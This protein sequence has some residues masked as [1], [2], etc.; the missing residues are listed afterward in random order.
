MNN[1]NNFDNN[2]KASLSKHDLQILDSII[3]KEKDVFGF[4][5]TTTT[6][7]DKKNR[8]LQGEEEKKSFQLELEA[9]Q[10]AEMAFSNRETKD[11][12]DSILKSIATIERAIEIAPHLPSPYN[13]KAQILRQSHNI[14]P[15]NELFS[16][17]NIVENLH[18][19]LELAPCEEWPKVRVLLLM[20]L[21]LCLMSL[22][23]K[24]EEAF[25]Y[26]KE[27]AELGGGKD[28]QRLATKCNPYSRLCNSIMS[29]ILA[30]NYYS[31]EDNQ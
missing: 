28:A 25:A 20:Q 4:S 21:G 10:L 11:Y 15:D 16:L 2:G 17:E 18:K 19:G 26:F 12:L 27:A 1:S 9:I 29:E 6:T 5:N 14:F 8:E 3:L 31:M 30:K 23:G 7:I 13:N 24:D 22:C